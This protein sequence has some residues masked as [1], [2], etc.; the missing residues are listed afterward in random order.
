MAKV[1]TDVFYCFVEDRLVNDETGYLSE[2]SFK[3]NVEVTAW[4][5]LTA[6][7]KEQKGDGLRKGLLIK[8]EPNLKFSQIL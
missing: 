1:L 2:A 8:K 7:N 3:Q 5:F 4:V 6:Y